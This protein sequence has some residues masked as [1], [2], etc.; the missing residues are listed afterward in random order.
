MIFADE[1]GVTYGVHDKP[2][3]PKS[4]AFASFVSWLN[5]HGAKKTATANNM[6]ATETT[7]KRKMRG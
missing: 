4:N 1:E 3:P 2:Q 7:K 6:I 5:R